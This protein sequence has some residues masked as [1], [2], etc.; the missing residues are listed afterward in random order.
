MG[1]VPGRHL[2]THLHHVSASA[3]SRRRMHATG[4]CVVRARVHARVAAA[5]ARCCCHDRRRTGSTKEV[6]VGLRRQLQQG[7]VC[8]HQLQARQLHRGHMGRP[9]AA[10]SSRHS[11]CAHGS[12]GGTR[13]HASARQSPPSVPA[14]LAGQAAPLHGAAMGAGGHRTAHCLQARAGQG[15]SNRAQRVFNGTQ[16]LLHSR[17]ARRRPWACTCTPL[18]CAPPPLYAAVPAPQPTRRA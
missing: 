14:R 17:R 4:C 6:R 2:S 18:A 3:C 15:K 8:K 5:A 10:A 1:R 16:Q 7:P 13:L 9:G 12:R 11:C